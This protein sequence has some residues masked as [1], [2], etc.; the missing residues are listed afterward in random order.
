MIGRIG[1]IQRISSTARIAAA[2]VSIATP[3]RGMTRR[4]QS[5][6]IAIPVIAAPSCAAAPT[7]RS[8]AVTVC[9]PVTIG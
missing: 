5:R 2:A 3:I 4:E 6:P 7:A 1:E 9:L 8:A